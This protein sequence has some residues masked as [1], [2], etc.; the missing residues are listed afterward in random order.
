MEEPTNGVPT[1]MRREYAIE[2]GARV[3]FVT[4]EDDVIQYMGN[5]ERRY[6]VV[7][8]DENALLLIINHEVFRVELIRPEPRLGNRSPYSTRI[9]IKG[10]N[11]NVLVQ[12]KKQFLLSKR[13]NKAGSERLTQVLVAP[14][15]GLVGR[16]KVSEGS[17][18]KKGD[19]LIVLEAMKM[20]NELKA[21]LDGVVQSVSVS[22]GI[23]VEKSTLLMVLKKG[24]TND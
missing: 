18:V 20:E 3:G 21:E 24:P 1:G 23:A 15:P 12:E 16:V 6:S 9:C 13:M 17:I 19:G 7:Q 4:L 8:V 2:I 10:Q 22:R 14:M 11:Y 5:P